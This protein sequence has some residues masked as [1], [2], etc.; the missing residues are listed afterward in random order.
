MEVQAK[1]SL[2]PGQVEQ[3]EYADTER[4]DGDHE[5]SD[6]RE[7]RRGR[8]WAF[9]IAGVERFGNSR[10]GLDAGAGGATPN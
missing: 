2:L 3:R 6:Q 7:S 5:Q 10:A 8:D 1:G 4:G 9:G